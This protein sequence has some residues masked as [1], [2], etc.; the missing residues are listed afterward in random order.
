MRLRTRG[1]SLAVVMPLSVLA[2]GCDSPP[3]AA[4]PRRTTTSHFSALPVDASSSILPVLKSTNGQPKVCVALLGYDDAA[5]SDAMDTIQALLEDTTN[6]WNALVQDYPGWTVQTITPNVSFATEEC[7]A[8]NG[9]DFNVNVWHDVQQ[10]QSEYCAARFL[11]ICSAATRWDEK[12]MFLGPWNR[13]QVVD[14]L[15]PFTILH[16]YGHLLG[17]GDTYRI[18]GFNDWE[19]EQPASVMNG[20]STELTSDDQ[21]GLWV[22]LRGIETGVRS[23]D[24]FGTEMTMT[25]NGFNALMCDPSSAP[26]MTD[27]GG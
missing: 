14:E 22:T 17:L 8:A 19:G 5:A 27:D 15:A 11:T 24:G 3:P 21:L 13:D 4:E 16:E 6:Q 18:E 23:C 2:L 25:L 1:H 20:E 7:T 9:A 12:T 10:F 26:A